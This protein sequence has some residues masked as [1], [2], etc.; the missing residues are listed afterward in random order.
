M[1]QNI[2]ALLR[3]LAA[4]AAVGLGLAVCGPVQAQTASAAD[5]APAMQAGA[6][7]QIGALQQIKASRTAAQDKIGSRLYLALLHQRGDSRLASL[8]AYQFLAAGHDGRTPVEILLTRKDAA[9]TLLQKLDQLGAVLVTSKQ[10]AYRDGSITA[11]VKLRDLEALAAISQ[12]SRIR[13][14]L[15]ATT[16]AV[17]VSEGVKTHGA[18]QAQS[19]Y[20]ATG[21]GVKLCALSD[22]VDSLAA[23]IASGDLPSVDVIS[24]QAGSGD[25]GT[26][27]LEILHDVA[28]SATLGFASAF[29]GEGQFAQNIRDLAAAGCKVIVDD[30]IYYDES[31][32]QDG[33][34]AQAVNDVTAAGVLYFSSAGNENNKADANSGTWEGDFKA[35]AKA[36]PPPLAGIGALHDFGDGGVSIPITDGGSNTI[37]G[38]AESYD[39]NSGIASTDYDLYLLDS[40]LQNVV[41]SSTDRQNGS[42]GDDFPFESVSGGSAGQR[43]VV[44][45]FAA[46]STSSAPLFNLIDFRGSLKASL[47]TT[48]ATRGHSA[49]AAAFSTAATPAAASFDGVTPAGPYPGQFTS[50]NA[51]ESF[52]SDGPRRI[53]LGPTGTELTPGN[54]TSSGGVL[55]QKPDVTAADGVSTSAP[56]FDPFYGTS[57]AAPHAAAIAGLLKA[58]LPSL[59]ATD[60]RGLLLSTAT[61]IEAPGTD[62][63]TGAGIVMPVPALAAAGATPQAYLSAD[64]PLFTQISGDGDAYIEPNETWSVQIPLSN[65]G[66]ATAKGISGKLST[67]TPKL[68]V[69]ANSSAYAN[70]KAGKSASNSTPFV[71]TLPSNVAC[72][73]NIDLSLKVSYNG[74]ASPQTFPSSSA[75]GGPGVAKSFS[76]SGAPVA[77]P[78]AGVAASATISVSSFSGKV[79]DVNLSIDG[80]SCN[81]NVG[82]TT[83]GIDHSYVS[84]LEI[85]LVAPSGAVVKLIDNAGGSGNNFCQTVL[86]D[87]SGGSSIQ[88]VA[89]AQAP[90]TGS[91]KPAN[92]LAGLNGSAGKGTWTLQAQDFFSVDTGSIRAF[93]LQLSGPKV[94][95]AP[96]AP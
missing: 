59:T 31:P 95:D 83:V 89:A 2:S 33:P 35:S 6:A 47:A 71:F 75:S 87:Q 29:N 80:A 4:A 15:G 72:G 84:D 53:I 54:R 68:K 65:I 70:I 23:S 20:A 49:A 22:G 58:A 69:T 32:F 39:L 67:S 3:R 27:M 62:V 11:R 38:W 28:P 9:A 48:G 76:Y 92:P 52:S 64:A 66:G 18:D 37:L 8:T 25:E 55:R 81:A 19:V 16:H 10:S 93:T 36:N 60:I 82:S 30:V 43:L 7:Q 88:S 63:S 90:F 86:D 45:R 91:F 96:A 94:C 50:V 61:D 5:A 85:S 13:E 24:G 56:G 78:D 34:V 79:S 44:N 1:N 14:S 17:D 74:N 77:I 73:S 46:G 57:A 51:S 26:A 12:V 21:A 41:D 42:G 40:K